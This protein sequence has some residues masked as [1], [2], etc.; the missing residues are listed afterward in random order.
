MVSKTEPLGKKAVRESFNPAP[1]HRGRGLTRIEKKREYA[2]YAKRKKIVYEAEKRNKNHLVLFLA[3][4]GNNPN[5]MR[6]YLMG[7]K[8]AI[9]YAYD[10]APRI[11][12]KTPNLRPD[13]DLTEEKFKDGMCS[14]ANLE[15]LESKLSAIGI[16]RVHV[17]G[18][19]GEI[20][21]YKLLH[22]YTDD[23]IKEMLKARKAEINKLNTT[24]F[25]KVLHPD[26]HKQI[27]YIQKTVYHKTMNMNS[28]DRVALQTEILTPVFR[29]ADEYTIMAHGG[30][31]E[32][33]MAVEM[34]NTVYVLMMRVKFLQ[35]LELWDVV[36][37][38]RVGE[39]LAMLEVLLK[40]KIINKKDKE[41]EKG[42]AKN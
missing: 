26:I 40:G 22:E 29:L 4:D 30:R 19:T 42:E 17:K 9:I 1:N 11:G 20:V 36:T 16:E 21:Y 7:G 23:E 10:I 5:K 27:L 38:A 6:F 13:T 28:V 2:E 3:S 39:N 33:E 24:L 12:R 35:D 32:Y 8:S 34:L 18:E 14:I 41:E 25:S 31:D 37:C 15:L